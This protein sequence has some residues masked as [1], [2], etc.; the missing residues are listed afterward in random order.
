MGMN[1]NRNWPPIPGDFEVKNPSSCVAICT[2]GKKIEVST[3]Y[4]IIG[5]CKTENI[6]IERMIVNVI[7]NSCIRFFILAGPEIPG[8]KTGASVKCLHESGIDPSTRRILGAE[9]A[10]PY[11]ENVPIEAV[12]RFRSQVQLIS[13]VDVTDPGEIARVADEVVLRN[14]GPYPADPIW[15]E[16]KARPGKASSR[17]MGAAI[18]LLPEFGISFD[19]ASSLV[20]RMDLVA[21]VTTHPTTVGVVMKSDETGTALVGQEL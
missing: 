19:P 17:N 21:W 18:A 13:M 15:V 14:P 7:S 12:E 3:D 11:V 20:S 8:H 1:D 5:T 10:I 6:G 2:L 4:A 16:F 9:G